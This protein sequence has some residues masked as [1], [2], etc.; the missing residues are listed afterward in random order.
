MGDK[1]A[2]FSYF[3]DTFIFDDSP[4]TNPSSSLDPAPKWKQVLTRGFP[5]YRC[6]AHL[7]ADPDTGKMYMFGGFTNT[8]FVPECRQ[9]WNKGPGRSFGDLWQLKIDMQGGCFEGVDLA[10]EARTATN[11]PWRRCYNCSSAGSWKK[12]GGECS[13]YHH[14]PTRDR[15]LG[16]CR[17]RVFFCGPECMKE[18]WKEH[19]TTHGC[20]KLT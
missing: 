4:S 14:R 10:E 1:V 19:K 5:T 16:S 13:C 17:G 18:G 7:L 6:Q 9:A 15:S 3:A 11:G 8:T 12:C 20:A 2:S